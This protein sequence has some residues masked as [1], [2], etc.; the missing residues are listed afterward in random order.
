MRTDLVRH[1]LALAAVFLLA[2]CAG[3][4]VA[5]RPGFDFSGVRKVGLIDFEDFPNAAGSGLTVSRTFEQALLKANYQV[6]EKAKVSEALPGVSLDLSSG[7][8]PQMARQLGEALG[9]DAFILGKLVEYFPDKHSVTMV[10]V[11]EETRDPVIGQEPRWEKHNNQWVL[12]ERNVTKG[13]TTHKKSYKRPEAHDQSGTVGLVVRM[14][15]AKTGEVLWSGTDSRSADHVQ[16]AA[17]AVVD[18]IL[19]AVKPTWPK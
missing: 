12:V 18:R 2:A 3:P 17:Q 13:Y 10:N 5:Y 19:G 14:I 7:V 16:D 1:P 8:D 4:R 11:N 15:D 9:A 6:V